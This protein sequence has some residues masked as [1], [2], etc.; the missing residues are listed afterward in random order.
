M[1]RS[2]DRPNGRRPSARPACVRP[3]P[4]FPKAVQSAWNWSDRVRLGP[5]PSPAA[6][7]PAW[8]DQ[9]VWTLNEEGS[10]HA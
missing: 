6:Q 2:I 9:D 3:R 7:W 5:A 8:T 1:S 10:N 4:A